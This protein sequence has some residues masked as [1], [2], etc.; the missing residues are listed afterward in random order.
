[1]WWGLE[2]HVNPG[3]GRD[4]VWAY[5]V[6]AFGILPVLVPGVVMAIEPDRRRRWVMAPFLA[7]GVGVAAVLLWSM[8]RGPVGTA[9]GAHHIDYKLNVP[10]GT[11]VVGLYVLATCGSLLASTYRHVR[12]FGAVNLAAA[13]V[14]AR[15][16]TSG[17]A[18]LWCAWAAVAAGAITLHLTWPVRASGGRAGAR[19]HRRAGLVTQRRR[20][21]APC[22]A[23]EGP[24][25][26]GVR[27]RRWAARPSPPGAGRRCRACRWFG[28]R[29]CRSIRSLP[30]VGR[31]PITRAGRLCKPRP[32]ATRRPGSLRGARV[33]A[34]PS[35]AGARWGPRGEARGSAGGG[36][37]TGVAPP[38]GPPRHRGRSAARG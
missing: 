19:G 36:G 20:T 4:A 11:V 6:F 37:Q 28:H 17:F 27:A 23:P 10:A 16:A 3:V 30:L 24:P 1:M 9:L 12:I 34:R 38:S 14:L 21:A 13:I 18:S 7:L 31:G 15:L 26:G 2:G 8:A 33:C 32:A 29:R 35:P 5:L 25:Q 22:P